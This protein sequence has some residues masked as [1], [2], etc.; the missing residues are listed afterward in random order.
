[1]TQTVP[2]ALT[3]ATALLLASPPGADPQTD[4]RRELLQRINA[5]RTRAGAPPLQLSRPLTAVAQQH[6]E[7]VAARGTLDQ[8]PSSSDAVSGQI[9]RTGYQAREWTESLQ[10]T[11]RTPADLLAEW[12]RND[13]GTWRKLLDPAVRDLGIGVG[14]LRGTPLYSFLYAVPQAEAFRRE[15]AHL[16]DV[17]AVRKEMLERVNAVRRREKLAPVRSNPKLDQAAQ[18]HAADMLRRGFFDHRNPDG[19]LVRDRATAAGYTWRKIGE[20]IAEGQLS[21]DEVMKTWMNS[22]GHRRNILEPDFEELGIGLVVGQGPRGGYRV[23]WAQN[24]G[25]PR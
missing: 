20:N 6:A 13:L 11:G 8:P 17:A 9:R 23:V 16:R 2:L 5:E 25:T 7:E 3:L 18:G 19:E 1:M 4:V 22:P 10:M 14:R 24:F 15:T 12:S 21:V